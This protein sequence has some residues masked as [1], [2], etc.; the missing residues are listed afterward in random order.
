MKRVFC[1]CRLLLV[2]IL[3]ASATVTAHAAGT[4]APGPDAAG[5]ATLM[6]FIDAPASGALLTPNAN[7]EV[8]GWIVDTTATG[9]SGIDGVDVYL[10]PRD[11]GGTLLARAN[12]A[13]RRDDV[14][15]ALGNAY[16]TNSGFSA[17]FAQNGLSI[18][19]NT[20]TVYAH[21]PNK[22][23]WLQQ[24]EVR[25]PVPPDRRYAD[26]PLLIVRDAVPSLD[27]NQSTPT[28][29]LRGYAIDRNMPANVQVGVGGSG[30]NSVQVYL[31]GPRNAGNGGGIPLGSATLGEKNREATGF[32]DRFLMSGWEFAAHPGDFSVD[33]HE[34]FIYAS[35][36]FWPSETLVILP[37]TVH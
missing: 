10:G 20:L 25:I 22:G 37:F 31:D 33:R 5:D 8:R 27:V 30:V 1:W 16:W 12:V 4:W 7:I 15:A 35:S 32:G 13:I 26:D 17:V 11:Q 34:F 24:L 18:G 9:W 3:L 28:L 6:G 2:A 29:T 23:W 19:P 14:A 36:A 21:T